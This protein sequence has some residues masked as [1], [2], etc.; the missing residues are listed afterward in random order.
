LGGC[1]KT[2]DL[3]GIPNPRWVCGV[4]VGLIATPLQ[5]AGFQLQPEMNPRRGLDLI[6][7]PAGSFEALLD[8]AAGRHPLRLG[9]VGVTVSSPRPAVVDD[10]ASG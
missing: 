1:S 3:Q 8:A 7:A 10:A 5:I 2:A 9:A 4:D 6:A